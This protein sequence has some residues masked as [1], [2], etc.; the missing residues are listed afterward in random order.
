M[1]SIILNNTKSPRFLVA[2]EPIQTVLNEKFGEN[3]VNIVGYTWDKQRDICEGFIVE[4]VDAHVDRLLEWWPH[5]QLR[6][7]QIPGSEMIDL[8]LWAPKD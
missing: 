7:V 8:Q 5:V 3:S 6:E 2:M 1:R 4:V